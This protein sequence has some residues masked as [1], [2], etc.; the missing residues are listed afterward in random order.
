MA[1][2]RAA[3]PGAYEYEV[4]AAIEAVH[5]GRGAVS[6]AIRR[7]SAADRTRR[8]CT[9]RTATGRCRPASSC[10][11]T[12]RA[13]Y[14]YMTGDITRTYPVE[15]HVLAGAERHLPHRAA[16]AGGRHSGGQAGSVAPGRPPPDG[17]GDQGRPAEARASSPTP[18]ANS[19]GSGT[20]MARRTT[21]ASTCTTSATAAVRS[22]R[23]WRSR[24]SRASTSGRA[25]STRCRGRRRTSPSSNG[26]SRRSAST[27]TSACASRIRF[28][29][30]SPASGICR[31]AVPKTIDDIEALMRRRSTEVER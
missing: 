12:R 30:K 15:R 3:R 4:K 2:M 19:T 20:R 7:L 26:S 29:S 11:S 10:S 23:A 22:S 14:D 1:G 16:G 28:C 8:S 27:P 13:T 18:A 9:T 6:G 25:R 24:S 31:R 21:S 5:R 17:R